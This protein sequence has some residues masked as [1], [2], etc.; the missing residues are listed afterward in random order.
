MD[1][2]PNYYVDYFEQAFE[3][4]VIRGKCYANNGS[5]KG[6]WISDHVIVNEEKG[7]ITYT[8]ETD[9]INSTH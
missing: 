7:T 6:S 4:L 5:F 3:G 1:N 8:Y 2:N 9:M